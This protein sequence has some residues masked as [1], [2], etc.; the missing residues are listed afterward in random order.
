LNKFAVALALTSVAL[1]SA[2]IYFHAESR[3]MEAEILRL[4]ETV[5]RMLADGAQLRER[6]RTVESQLAEA[7]DSLAATGALCDRIFPSGLYRLETSTNYGA[8]SVGDYEIYHVSLL[9]SE[10][11]V[12]VGTRLNGYGI[13]TDFYFDYDGDG[14]IDTAL[15]ARFVREIPIAGN[16]VADRLLADSRVHQNLYG[17]FSCEW[18][19]AEFTSSDDMYARVSGT[20]NMLW[21][22]VQEHCEDIVEWIGAL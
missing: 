12:N 3:R 11:N 1:V 13:P 6:I 8:N 10:W 18:R 19:N 2:T 17:V 5:D 22:L 14:R 4:G 16:T 21:D 7:K 20:S 9:L 15:A